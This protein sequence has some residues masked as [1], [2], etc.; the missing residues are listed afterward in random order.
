[1]KYLLSSTLLMLFL[2]ISQSA[3]AQDAGK[4]SSQ[5]TDKLYTM[6]GL[7]MSFPI[8][9]TNDYFKPKISTTVGINLGLGNGGLFLYPK[10]S[11]HAYKFDEQ[12]TDPGYQT[13]IKSGRS[14]TY[15]LNLGLGYRKMLNKFSY[16]GFAGLGGGIILTP[17]VTH[18]NN[19]GTA[20]LDNKSNNLFMAEAGLGIEYNIGG[21]SL[22]VESGYMR[23]FKDI[24]SRNFSS[25]PISLGI[26]PNLSK[27]FNKK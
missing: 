25:V 24:Q 5:R 19:A 16:Y 9:E 13:A 8:G 27:I 3:S 15:L 14:T 18:D 11:L 4:N 26:K 12:V 21:A 2:T 20:T 7:G 22:F 23:G 1:M 17:R 6:S 10:V